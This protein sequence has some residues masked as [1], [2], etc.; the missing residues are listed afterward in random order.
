MKAKIKRIN[1]AKDIHLEKRVWVGFALLFLKEHTR[2]DYW[3]R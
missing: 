1:P 3:S 2:Y